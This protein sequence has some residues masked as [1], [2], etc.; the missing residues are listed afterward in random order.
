[1]AGTMLFEVIFRCINLK[2]SN[3]FFSPALCAGPLFSRKLGGTTQNYGFTHF[4]REVEVSSEPVMDILDR[5]D[6]RRQST[7]ILLET[8]DA[9]FETSFCLIDPFYLPM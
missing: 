9:N 5:C 4:I 8:L 6:E 1:M 3:Q 7:N 2:I